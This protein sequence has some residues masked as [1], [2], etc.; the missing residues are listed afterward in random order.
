ML[1]QI[2]L[3]HATF[4]DARHNAVALGDHRAD[5]VTCLTATHETC[6]I[7]CTKRDG[8]V[9]CR[10]TLGADLLRGHAYKAGGRR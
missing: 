1:G 4:T 6:A 2:H 7:S 10:P 8:I 3:A 5:Q 9:V